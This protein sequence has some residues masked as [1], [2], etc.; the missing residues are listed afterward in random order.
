MPTTPEQADLRM[1]VFGRHGE[2]PLP[3]LAPAT[4]ADCFAV[5]IEAAR[6]AIEAMTP[7][8][9][10]S[11]AYLANAVSEWTAPRIDA[12]PDIARLTQ[13]DDASAYSRDP[14][15]LARSWVAPG[16]PARSY[17]VGGIEKDAVSGNISYDPAN[18]ERMVQ[19]RAEKI[20]R[21][22]ARAT[23]AYLTDGPDA[24]DLLAIG[25]G[26][27]FGPIRQA[28]R[29]LRSAGHAVTHVHLRHLWPLPPDIG[30]V[31]R[32]YRRI[33]CAEMNSGHLTQM[34]R[35]TYLAPVEAVTQIT[36]RPFRISALESAFANR[37]PGAAS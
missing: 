7:V 22:A 25:W 1:A 20:A 6:I 10:L 30:D 8:I 28:A 21:I 4:P 18:H 33:V 26:S 12:L 27:T 31:M 17:R 9:V 36:G 29:N 16:T 15:T 19:L 37:L 5:M 13:G 3:V 32:R 2:A 35:S 23:G 24:G 34:L 14:D 11:D